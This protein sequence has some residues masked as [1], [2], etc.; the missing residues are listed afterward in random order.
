MKLLIIDFGVTTV[1]YFASSEF[2]TITKGID[3]L[4]LFFVDGG[5]FT[6]VILWTSLFVSED[7]LS[8][9]RTGLLGD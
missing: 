1:C 8:S 5:L 9:E 3:F 2:S 6:E 4:D 7:I